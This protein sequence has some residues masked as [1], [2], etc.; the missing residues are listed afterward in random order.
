MVVGAPYVLCP[1][2]P[3]LYHVVEIP[4]V[5]GQVLCATQLTE[6][7]GFRLSASLWLKP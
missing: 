7:F 2:S 3:V 1:L 5:A 4:V 6:S